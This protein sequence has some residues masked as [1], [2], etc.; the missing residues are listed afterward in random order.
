MRDLHTHTNFCDGK[1]TPNE[2]LPTFK[3]EKSRVIQNKTPIRAI[4]SCAVPKTSFFCSSPINITQN[5][6]TVSE[7]SIVRIGSPTSPTTKGIRQSPPISPALDERITREMKLSF[8][9]FESTDFITAPNVEQIIGISALMPQVADEKNSPIAIGVVGSID[10]KKNATPNGLNP[11]VIGVSPRRNVIAVAIVGFRELYVSRINAV[12]LSS[13]ER[14]DVDDVSKFFDS[15]LF[16]FL[17]FA[18]SEAF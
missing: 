10:A 9:F 8:P 14:R 18:K 12:K 1:N 3:T 4:T 11:A 15:I 16:L 7:S 5:S 6:G 13:S 17:H 2:K